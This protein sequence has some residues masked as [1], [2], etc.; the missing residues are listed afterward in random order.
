[1]AKPKQPVSM[2]AAKCARRVGLTVRALRVYERHG[3]IEPRRTS[4]GWRCYG[5]KELQRLNLI[6][7]LKAFGM[8]LEQIGKLLA[9]KSPPL[10]LVLQMQLQACSARKDAV[11]RAL[12]LVRSALATI[13]GGKPLSLEELCKLTRSMEMGKE[14]GTGNL[15]PIVRELINEKIAPEEERAFLNWM[16]A[17]PAD[18]LKAAQEF[19]PVRQALLRALRGLQE[20]KV[21]PA[22][23]EVQTLIVQLKDLGG[24]YDSRK[25]SAAMF[26]WNPSLAQKWAEVGERVLARRM[27]SERATPDND[28][29]AYLRAAR[30]AAPWSQALRQVTDEATKLVEQKVEPTSEPAKALANR[31]ARICSDHSLGDPL[32]YARWAPTSLFRKP[33]AENARLTSAWAFLG[34]ALEASAPGAH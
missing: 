7:T 25:R 6:V 17:R 19:G 30:A 13:G 10:A 22:A 4:K 31:L 18:D 14:M 27:S 26:E 21:D 2:G 16:A 12:A 32:V 29:V 5:P 3:L 9:K 23:P 1:M 8:T 20:K 24:H 11:E 28:F 15:R 33:P 34:S